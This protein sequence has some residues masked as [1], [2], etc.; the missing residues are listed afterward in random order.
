MSDS[1]APVLTLTPNG[2]TL[3]PRLALPG[4]LQIHLAPQR[5]FFA[6][7]MAQALR[8]AG[9]GQRVLVVQFLKGGI[10]QGPDAPMRLVEHLDWVRCNLARCI[11]TPDIDTSEAQALQALWQVAQDAV[12]AK[13]Y[14][15][16]VL[17][18]LGLAIHLDLIPLV[19]VFALLQSRPAGVD[20]I[21]TGTDM[22]TP[23]LDLADQVTQMRRVGPET[24]A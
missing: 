21:L 9:Q 24:V 10:G 15:L 17:D 13:Q 1:S 18:E 12:R 22:P 7:V 6:E 19:E 3:A 14:N 11:D 8:L 4:R 16:V 5:H 20:L 2:N 23:I